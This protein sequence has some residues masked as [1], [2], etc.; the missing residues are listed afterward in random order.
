MPGPLQHAS[1]R[2]LLGQA[3]VTW[4]QQ[5]HSPGRQGQNSSRKRNSQGKGIGY[6][7]ATETFLAALLLHSPTTLTFLDGCAGQV[8]FTSWK[9][10]A[11][12][13][14]GVGRARLGAD[15]RDAAN[16]QVCCGRP[17]PA[18]TAS[19]CQGCTQPFTRSLLH[20]HANTCTLVHK[21][22]F[23]HSHTHIH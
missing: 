2:C 21:H 14:V 13:E 16:S 1:G 22:T 8:A 3:G 15:V 9:G 6:G 10:L 17:G 19:H 5:E 23:T 4:A 7:M 20:A 11:A 18:G 12:Y